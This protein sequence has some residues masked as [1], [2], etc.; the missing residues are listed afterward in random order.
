MNVSQKTCDFDR[1]ITS[2]LNASLNSD[3]NRTEAI[4]LDAVNVYAE[5][6]L[7][8]IRRLIRNENIRYW[9]GISSLSRGQRNGIDETARTL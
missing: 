9:H 1:C 7:V 3:I 6:P 5:D 2:G 4:N 8:S